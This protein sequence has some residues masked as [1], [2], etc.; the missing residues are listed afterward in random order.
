MGRNYHFRPGSFYR[1]D[2]RTGFPTRAEYTRKQWNN[3]IV[4]EKVWEPRQPQDL[5]RGVKDQ[6][7][8][9][10]ARPLAPAQFVGPVWTTTSCAVPIWSRIIPL[11]SLGSFSVGDLVAIMT[12][13]DGGT[14]FRAY[15]IGVGNYPVVTGSLATEGGSAIQTEDGQDILVEAYAPGIVINIPIPGPALDGAQVW[16]YGP[17]EGGPITPK[18]GIPLLFSI[19]PNLDY[20]AIAE[21]PTTPKYSLATEG[22]S[23]IQ[24]EDGQDILV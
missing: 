18:Y 20:R 14:L 5:V 13:I 22:G 16:N 10:D 3:L 9:Q 24:T 12:N 23:A 6:Q 21:G 4:D 17:I 15:V 19:I 2:D 11:A 8:V 1:V 7:S